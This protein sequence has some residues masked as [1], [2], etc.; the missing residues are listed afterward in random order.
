MILNVFHGSNIAIPKP[1]LHAGRKDIDF[2]QG[3]YTTEDYDMACKWA[4][5]K[6][7][8][9]I[10][11]YE[12]D[13]S[14]LN[15]AKLE[16]NEEWVDF[17]ATNRGYL[18]NSY[19]LNN[20]DI[21]IGPT[22]DDKLY[23]TLENYFSGMLSLEDTIKCLNIMAFSNQVVFKSEKA[24]EQLK[25]IKPIVLQPKDVD[26]YNE[27]AKKDRQIAMKQMQ[28]YLHIKNQCNEKKPETKTFSNIETVPINIEDREGDS[29]E[30]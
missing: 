6:K 17:V 12:L 23:G 10:S 4:S 22:A 3:F 20:I 1:N 7:N 30:R 19:N 15:V 13:L 14:G 26:Y 8:P 25:F 18:D 2:G 29:Y 21:I 27:L 9:T 11:K 16:L 5:R 28:D 24:I